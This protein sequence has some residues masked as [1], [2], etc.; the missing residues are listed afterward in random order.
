V[1]VARYEQQAVL[2][3]N[4]EEA[5]YRVLMTREG[6]TLVEARYSVRNNQ[7]NF[8]KIVLPQDAVVWSASL[9]GRAVH[10]GQA[11]D[12]SI[13]FPLSKSRAGEDAQPF[14]IQVIYQAPGAKW[15]DKA[16][17]GLALP[18]LDLPISRTG[19]LLYHPPG[20]KVNAEPGT[21]RVGDYQQPASTTLV[22]EPRPATSNAAA[23]QSDLMQQL[24]NN[25]AQAATQALVDRYR[26]NDARKTSATSP[27]SLPF[28]AVGP[29][30][31]LVSELTS[32]NQVASMQFS[33][34]RESK[35]GVK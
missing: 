11:P 22:A 6:K 19:V 27:A 35:G 7:R 28:P 26:A 20:Y 32:E 31:F 12:G 18:S 2:T 3:A 29:S 33:Y 10:P 21:F 14:A 8:A 16:R 5:R 24:N 4:I 13:L 34:Q 23:Q 9:D 15:Q 17:A 1:Q 25:A 30:L